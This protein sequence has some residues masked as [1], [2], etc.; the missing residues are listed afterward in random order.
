MVRRAGVALYAI[1]CVRWASG[2][3]L[4]FEKPRAPDVS[5][6]DIEARA[7]KKS[8]F[9]TTIA[10]PLPK[11]LFAM[12]SWSLALRLRWISGEK[13]IEPLRRAVSAVTAMP[14]EMMETMSAWRAVLV[15]RALSVKISEMPMRGRM[16]Q[17]RLLSPAAAAPVSDSAG[18]VSAPAVGAAGV[19][20]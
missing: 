19:S 17:A 11:R 14:G 5:S 9:G 7:S 4:E 15:P 10:L 18:T 13:S 20:P 2:I 8:R 12:R 6:W 16:S 3:R 1:T